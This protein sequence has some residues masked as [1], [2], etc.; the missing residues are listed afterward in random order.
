[1]ME[2]LKNGK[3]CYIE[4]RQEDGTEKIILAD[5]VERWNGNTCTIRIGETV[6]ELS[7]ASVIRSAITPE[8]LA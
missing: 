4:Y 3:P 1:M 2:W 8:E 5:R 6:I 7:L